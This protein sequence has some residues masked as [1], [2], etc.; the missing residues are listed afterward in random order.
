VI[1][2]T[3]I[4]GEKDWVDMGHMEDET[5]SKP[6]GWWWYRDQKSTKKEHPSLTSFCL[7]WSN[8]TRV[9]EKTNIWV[10][11]WWK[12]KKLKRGP[13]VSHALGYSGDWNTQR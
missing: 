3:V 10:S 4:N 2:K 13:H 11:V 8:K 1:P 9:T 6:T 12:T 5:D 7:L